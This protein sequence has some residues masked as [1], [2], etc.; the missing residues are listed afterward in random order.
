MAKLMFIRSVFTTVLVRMTMWLDLKIEGL[1]RA[2]W[3]FENC[4]TGLLPNIIL[5]SVISG[6][7]VVCI[8]TMCAR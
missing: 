3:L 5:M 1:F 6:I 7:D 8:S 4:L 2:I